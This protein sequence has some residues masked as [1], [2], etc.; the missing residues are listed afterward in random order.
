[1]CKEG[2]GNVNR[3]F[4]GSL[5]ISFI[6]VCE[7]VAVVLEIISANDSLSWSTYYAT[8]LCSKETFTNIICSP[9][10]RLNLLCNHVG[11]AFRARAINA[12]GEPK[13]SN[14]LNLTYTRVRRCG[15]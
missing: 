12:G 13:G 14:D 8:G 1:M 7:P 5:G 9:N 11:K 3:L 6:V 10:S 4:N 15:Q 2:Y